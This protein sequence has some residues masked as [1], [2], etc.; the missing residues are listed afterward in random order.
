MLEMA[1]SNREILDECVLFCGTGLGRWPVRRG[2]EKKASAS[3]S[4]DFARLS[5]GLRELAA[6]AHERPEAPRGREEPS[7]LT[8]L[9]I[10]GRQMNFSGLVLG[11]IETK[12]CKKICV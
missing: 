1:A 10:E 2:G 6:E 7:L 12:F 9:E 5:G 11:C 8:R 4:F 3:R